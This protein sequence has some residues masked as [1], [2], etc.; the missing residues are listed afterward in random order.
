MKTTVSV[1][2]RQLLTERTEEAISKLG[3]VPGVQGLV[4]GGSIGRGEPWRENSK[5]SGR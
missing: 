4:L 3:E 1:R 5:S 2:W